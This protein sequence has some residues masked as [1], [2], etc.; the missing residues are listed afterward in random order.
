MCAVGRARSCSGGVPAHLRW[1]HSTA[2]HHGAGPWAQAECQEQA[3]GGH[4]AQQP[5][6]L[7]QHARQGGGA[8]CQPPERL[9]PPQPDLRGGPLALPPHLQHRALRVRAPRAARPRLHHP[10]NDGGAFRGGGGQR[11]P[12]GRG[13]VHLGGEDD[14]GGGA[15][16]AGGPAGRIAPA[17][18]RPYQGE[19]RPGRGA[20]GATWRALRPAR[21]PVPGGCGGRGRR[22]GFRDEAVGGQGPSGGPRWGGRA[23]ARGRTDG[24]RGERQNRPRGLCRGGGGLRIAWQRPGRAAHAGPNGR[25]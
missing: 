7:L 13:D 3:P 1:H 22:R 2:G 17:G 10:H 16:G 5:A 24:E 12:P 21:S 15:W 9:P 20:A 19:E 14:R 6:V 8:Q 18:P 23:R 25:P 11:A 4:P